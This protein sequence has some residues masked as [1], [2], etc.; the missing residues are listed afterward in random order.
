M[1]AL[2]ERVDGADVAAHVDARAVGQPAVEDRDIRAQRRDAAGG[3]LGRAGL[4][5]DDDVSLALEELPDAAAH[6]LVVVE[7]E[8]PDRSGRGIVRGRGLGSVVGHL[9]KVVALRDA[10]RV[11]RPGSSG[12]RTLSAGPLSSTLISDVATAWKKAP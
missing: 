2:I 7:Q 8:D 3:L 1:S 9:P 12:P 10:D 6:E 4:A 11:D 5:H